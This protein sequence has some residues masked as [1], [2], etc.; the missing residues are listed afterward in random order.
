MYTMYTVYSTT[1]HFR[2]NTLRVLYAITFLHLQFLNKVAFV[3]FGL[4]SSSIQREYFTVI[5]LL[6]RQVSHC[7]IQKNERES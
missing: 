5:I 2:P 3:F 1:R 6:K 7:Y 4:C